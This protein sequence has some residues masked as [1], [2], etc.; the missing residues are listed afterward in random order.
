MT[1][2]SWYLAR[3]VCDDFTAC[4]AEIRARTGMPKHDIVAALLRAAVSQAESVVEQFKH[5]PPPD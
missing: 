2:R 5:L 4:V 3:D 1:R